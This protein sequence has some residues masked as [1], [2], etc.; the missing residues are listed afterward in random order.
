[1]L[2]VKI[3]SLFTERMSDKSK[4]RSR[5]KSVTKHIRVTDV[6][7]W[8][9]K[10][11]VRC[12]TMG[13]RAAA[14]VWLLNNT[15][16]YYENIDNKLT[17]AIG[18]LGLLLSG[19]GISTVIADVEP[20][21]VRIFNGIILGLLLLLSCGKLAIT[22]YGFSKRISKHRW[23][24][25]SFA[26]LFSDIQKT[27]EK[28][29]E[30]RESFH[31]F[32]ERIQEKEFSLNRKT[33]YVPPRIIKKYYET[34]KDRALESSILFGNIQEIDVFIENGK[35][36]MVSKPPSSEAITTMLQHT[37]SVRHKTYERDLA[38]SRRNLTPISVAGSEPALDSVRDDNNQEPESS[39]GI[40]KAKKASDVRR[41]QLERYFIGD[42]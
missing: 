40:A 11:E 3:S 13:D 38:E 23:A 1:M 39:T 33:P 18:V 2:N 35:N 42:D 36:F 19:G 14:L 41:Y 10:A 31:T 22:L 15:A 25:A 26:G 6:E 20:H 16:N 5:S 29:A 24:S 21:I 32:F 28:P 4:H 8:T 34:F 27:L 12:K 37:K 7:S 9:N 17:I 30:K